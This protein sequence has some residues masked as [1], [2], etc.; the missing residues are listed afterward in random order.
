MPESNSD[1]HV[2]GVEILRKMF[3][4]ANSGKGIG[5]EEAKLLDA[6]MLRN[7]TYTDNEGAQIDE[8]KK[9]FNDY[10]DFVK[11]MKVYPERHAIVYPALGI[12]DEG[13]EVAGK[14]KK[15]LR[16]DRELDRKELLKEAGDVLWYLASL[17]DDLGF[18]FQDMVD[19]NV[20][21]LSS[22]KERG[23]LKGDGDNR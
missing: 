10:Q 4:Q 20:K 15:W 3:E 8:R 2:F 7:E 12:V 16:G 23:V 14:V 22:R 1:A 13:G 9:T 6:D 17:A 11:T 18:T 5:K 21:K 19:E